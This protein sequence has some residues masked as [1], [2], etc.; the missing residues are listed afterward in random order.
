VLLGT[1]LAESD[2]GAVVAAYRRLLPALAAK[3]GKEGGGR[4]PEGGYHRAAHRLAVL[5]GEGASAEGAAPEYV[6]LVFD[7]MAEVFEAKLVEHL[8]YRVR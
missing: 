8:G 3:G 6:K 1:V 2:R 4:S 5:T 7:G